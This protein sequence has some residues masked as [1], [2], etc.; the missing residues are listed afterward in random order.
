MESEVIEILPLAYM[1]GRT[2]SHACIIL[3]EGQNA[4]AS[5]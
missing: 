1:R 3:D 5:R 4:T 2:L